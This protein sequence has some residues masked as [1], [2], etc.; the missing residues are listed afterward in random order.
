MG[1]KVQVSPEEYLSMSFHGPDREYV[2]GEI[3]ERGVPAYVHSRCQVR[4]SGIF[5]NLGRQKP[6]Y[7]GSDLRVQVASDVYRVPDLAV[8]V[9]DEPTE[10]VPSTPPLITIEIVSPGDGLIEVSEKLEEYWKWGVRHVWVADPHTRKLYVYDI[11]GLRQ[12]T[13]FSVPELEL[14]V[15][16]GQLF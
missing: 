10:Q 8:F 9:G 7:A 14:E 1:T 5:F 6:V 4:L 12:V 13:R 16:P 2:H 15:T 11:A 3:R